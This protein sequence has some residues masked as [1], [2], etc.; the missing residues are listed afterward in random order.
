MKLFALFILAGATLVHTSTAEDRTVQQREQEFRSYVARTEKERA[1]K[2]L[3]ESQHIAV[4][5]P[6]KGTGQ[7]I[8][9]VLKGQFGVDPVG[10][11]RV[12][13]LWN[14]SGFPMQRILAFERFEL[15][16]VG[17]SG[18]TVS[19]T[20]CFPIDDKGRIVISEQYAVHLRV[21]ELIRILEESKKSNKP[22]QT[23]GD[24]PSK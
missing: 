4:C 7:V 23:D 12:G 2:D 21:E 8:Q 13:E 1:I 20:R 14:S 5:E 18:G 3:T 16:G 22:A 11:L 24:K 19:S 15:G 9:K 17:P 10:Q 6:R